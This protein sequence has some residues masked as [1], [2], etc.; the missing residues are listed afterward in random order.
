[1]NNNMTDIQESTIKYCITKGKQLENR[2]QEIIETKSSDLYLSFDEKKELDDE[3]TKIYAQMA[4]IKIMYDEAV[5]ARET[6]DIFVEKTNH[7]SEKS[8]MYRQKAAAYG[9]KWGFTK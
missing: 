6:Y 5:N 7:H 8:T 9:K 1:M 4:K 3:E 2:L